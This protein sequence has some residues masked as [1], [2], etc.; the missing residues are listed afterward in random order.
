MEA[1]SS[2]WKTH[3]QLSTALQIGKVSPLPFDPLEANDRSYLLLPEFLKVRR[4]GVFVHH[5]GKTL[6]VPKIGRNSGV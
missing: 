4:N 6:F 2:Q 3:V 1:G 5:P